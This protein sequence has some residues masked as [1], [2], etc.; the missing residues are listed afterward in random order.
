[1]GVGSGETLWRRKKR[2]YGKGY[3][4]KRKRVYLEKG[5]GS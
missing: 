1:M 2:A 3:V 4:T 5:R